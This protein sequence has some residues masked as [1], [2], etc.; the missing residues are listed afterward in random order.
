MRRLTAIIL[1]LV[2]CVGMIIPASAAGNYTHG[3]SSVYDITDEDYLREDFHSVNDYGD[4][5]GYTGKHFSQQSDTFPD[6]LVAIL[7]ESSYVPYKYPSKSIT[8]LELPTSLVILDGSF[9]TYTTGG[10]GNLHEVNFD[11]LTNLKYIGGWFQCTPLYEID[12]RNTKVVRISGEGTFSTNKS[13]AAFYAPSTLRRI[14]YGVFHDCPNMSLIELNEGLEYIGGYNFGSN[15]YVRVLGYD[16]S[17]KH[18]I[19][20]PSTVTYIGEGGLPTHYYAWADSDAT[21]T[22]TISARYIVYKGSYGEEWCKQNHVEYIYATDRYGNIIPRPYNPED[23]LPEDLQFDP[24]GDLLIA[25]D[26]IV[27]SNML[28]Y[29]DGHQEVYSYS[30]Y[31]APGS[32]IRTINDGNS[33]EYEYTSRNIYDSSMPDKLMQENIRPF[34][35]E[36]YGSGYKKGLT[37][38]IEGEGGEFTAYGIYDIYVAKANGERS[39]KYTIYLDNWAGMNFDD[40]TE[41]DY[42]GRPV[43]WAINRGITDGTSDTTFSP[44]AT[45]TNAQ[46]LTFLWRAKNCPEPILNSPFAKNP[47]TE[48]TGNEYYYK[49]AV[50]AYQ[51]GLISGDTFDAN[52]PST[53]AM[54]VTYQWKLAG[55]PGANAA[56]FTDVDSS[57]EYAQAVAWAVKEGIT[58]GTSDTTFSPDATCTRGQIVTFLWRDLA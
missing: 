50:W 58:D 25:G 5:I 47:F 32:Y 30:A 15:T 42:F 17:M 23:T 40:V 10:Y 36:A 13:L 48:L 33:F 54:T 35:T 39:V 2:L 6:D 52:S 22:K 27:Y 29:E 53:R 16:D 57:A 34:L 31:L 12:L 55:M 51:Q 4:L 11:E 45:C 43:L 46:I 18:Y 20:I 7:P 24:F 37:W 56:N 21:T 1:A 38:Q 3:Y 19:T 44:D 41:F 8:R 26:G 14:D 49:A 28:E 9:E